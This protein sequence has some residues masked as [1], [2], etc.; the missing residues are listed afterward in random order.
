ME[1]P[2]DLR[3]ADNHEWTRTDGSRV[4]MGISDY[5]QDALGDIVF[6]EVP[7]VGR[8]VTAGEAIAEVES[9]KSVSDVY[10]PVTG[11][12]VEVNSALENNPELVNSDPFGEGWFAVI[13]ATD[14]SELD[15]LMDVDAYR[16]VAQ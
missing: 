12:V 4:T 5:A 6:V 11:T 14:L 1:Y 7:E 8:Q 13:D 2:T 16:E 15:K 3:Y 10:A 9:T